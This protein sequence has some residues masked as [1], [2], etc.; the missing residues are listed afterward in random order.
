MAYFPLYVKIK[1]AFNHVTSK[2]YEIPAVTIVDAA[3]IANDWLADLDAVIGGQIIE[4]TLGE[5]L[6]LSGLKASPDAGASTDSGVTFSGWLERT[7]PKKFTVKIPTVPLDAAWIDENG[8]VDLSDTSIAAVV[9]DFTGS[10]YLTV[11][12]REKAASFI[13]GKLDIR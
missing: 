12:D 3:V 13:S 2:R 6:G 5:Y 1:D 11:S 4:A 10:A 7:P 8:N 9:D